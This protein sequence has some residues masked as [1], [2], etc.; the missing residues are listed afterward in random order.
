MLRFTRDTTLNAALAE[1]AEQML[2]ACSAGSA[3]ILVALTAVLMLAALPAAAQNPHDPD[4]R[5][6]IRERVRDVIRGTAPI[7]ERSRAYQGRDRGTEQT[8]RFSRRAKIGRDGRVTIQNIAGNITVTAGSGDEVSIEAIKRTRAD[9][10]Q[11]AT[12]HIIVDERPGRVEVRTEH[13]ARND[14]VSVDY[15]VTV[16]A[17]ASLELKSISGTVKVTGVQGG[18]RADTI[19]GNIV[20]ASTPR[21]EL[22]K[23][24]SGDVDLG[25]V[26]T[27]TDVS[28]SS[29]SGSVRAKGLKARSLDLGTI[30]G[31]VTLTNVTCDRLGV[32]S[33]SG[34]VD[35]SGALAR[36][37]R[38]DVNSHSG[39]IRL[40]IPTDI[41]FELTANTF[42]GSI[43]S[44]IPVTLGPTSA[45]DDRR[46]PG[47][48]RSTRA[49]F[50]DGSASLTVRTFSGD[51][52]ITK[53]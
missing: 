2:S 13:T 27:D 6:V 23:S 33:V 36:N 39:T 45:R 21:L 47:P 46:R 26:S 7:E 22:A 17:S 30:S 25:D 32:R 15:T 44:D 53:R 18:V 10:S 43:R 50:G 41:G 8:D 51:I 4:P 49:T 19:S 16:P 12:V 52:V 40:T 38:Y 20:T 28:A 11:L 35:F 48:G 9:A 31:D 42:S 5:L 14:R 1:L 37:G 29:I 24:V 3:L 34:N